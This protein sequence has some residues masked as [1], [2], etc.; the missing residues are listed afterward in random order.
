M[1]DLD[2]SPTFKVG[3]VVRRSDAFIARLEK[4]G[5]TH[6]RVNFHGLG[7]VTHLDDP[8]IWVQWSP[9]S[10]PLSAYIENELTPHYN[11]IQLLL[12]ML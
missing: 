11:G 2:L 1:P 8:T 6:P 9:G 7:V 4:N 3:Q 12:A 5:A 10:G